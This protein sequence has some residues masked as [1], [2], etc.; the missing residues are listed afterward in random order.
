M[1]LV[2]TA[3]TLVD[4][5]QGNIAVSNIFNNRD[6]YQ[7]EFHA[8][9]CIR[10]DAE[11]LAGKIQVSSKSQKQGIDHIMGAF[12]KSMTLHPLGEYTHM[13]TMASSITLNHEC[14]DYIALTLALPADGIWDDRPSLILAEAAVAQVTTEL[15]YQKVE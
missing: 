5:A 15:V 4:A 9:T 2:V 1:K 7:L 12:L 3:Q 8:P 13:L 6:Y 11:V 10:S 14:V